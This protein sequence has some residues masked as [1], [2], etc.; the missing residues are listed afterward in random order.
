M[1]GKPTR[2]KPW[3]KGKIV[4]GKT[5]LKPEEV[6]AIRVV[7]SQPSWPIRDA[8]MFAVAVDSS[9]RGADMM[10]L[11]VY[12]LML[13]GSRV[14]GSLSSRVRRRAALWRASPLNC[15]QTRKNSCRAT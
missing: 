6:H 12:D 11:K 8:V 14:N 2:K 9:L 3:N 4:G 5:A 10:K 15:H 1:N 7:L 13:A